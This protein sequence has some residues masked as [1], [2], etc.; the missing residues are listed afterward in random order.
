MRRAVAQLRFV[1][2][3]TG[4]ERAQRKGDVKQFHSAESDTERKGQHRQGKQFTRAGGCATREDPRYQAAAH[5]HHNG[6]KGDHFADGDTHI[7]RQRGKADVVF[8]HHPGDGRQQDQRQDHHQ[9]FNNQ[10]ADG[11]LPT[12]AVY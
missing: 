9:I 12:L 10:P 11:D 8:F 6:D 7:Q 5:H 3:H 4:E 2:H 1:Q